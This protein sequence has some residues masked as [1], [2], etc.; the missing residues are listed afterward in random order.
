[1]IAVFEPRRLVDRCTVCDAEPEQPCNETF[2]DLPAYHYTFKTHL[3]RT[4]VET[5]DDVRLHLIA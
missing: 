4:T 5:L 3:V 1:M 2:R